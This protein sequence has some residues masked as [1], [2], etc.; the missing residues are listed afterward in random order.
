MGVTTKPNSSSQAGPRRFGRFGGSPRKLVNPYDPSG[1]LNA[2][3]RSYLHVN[4]SHCHQMGA[5]GT[6]NIDFRIDMPLERTQAIN[7]RPY[8][9]SFDLPGASILTPGDPYTSVLYYRLAKIGGGRMPYLGSEF[10]DERGLR[11][12]HDWIKQLPRRPEED[13]LLSRLR[14]PSTSEFMR[15]DA[16]TKLLATTSGALAL[17]RAVADHQGSAPQ[18][19]PAIR[20][21]AIQA[22]MARPDPQIRD[23][24]ERFLPEEQRVKRLGTSID[25]KKL[26]ALKGDPARGKD[27]F[28]NNAAMQ[29][30]TCHRIGGVG[31]TV[32]PD[33][34]AIGKKHDRAKLLENLLEPSKVIEPPYVSYLVETKDGQV[35]TGILAEKSDKQIVLKN[36]NDKETRIPA[37][38]VVTLLPQKTSIMPEQLLRD[39]TAEQVADLLAYLETLK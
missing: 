20:Q 22:A 25:P 36:A 27:L 23:L 37:D 15:E 1:D 34:T 17:A 19:L 31:S 38:K 5:G 32:G 26:L 14:E 39:M 7:V 28:F 4:C 30:K 33:L 10:I 21:E 6:T 9:G 3:A 29:C 2:R 24:F 13:T 11:L 18:L 16:L 35:H 12:I 8:Q